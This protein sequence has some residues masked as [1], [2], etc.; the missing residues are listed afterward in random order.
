MRICLR[1]RVLEPMWFPKCVKWEAH[2]VTKGN[3][4]R[5]HAPKSQDH[6]T[7][8]M[9][10]AAHFNQR[11]WDLQERNH[12]TQWYPVQEPVHHHP[13]GNETRN[14]LQ[15]PCKSPWYWSVLTES[16]RCSFLNRNEQWNKGSNLQVFC[17]RSFKQET[18]QSH[19]RCQ[20]LQIFPG[21][22]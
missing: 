22:D 2:A 20:Q 14:C 8:R 9:A 12:S 6:S 15:K 4:T 18:P 5:L 1:S 11:I 16:T 13:P 3:R 21:V 7:C 10:R 17:V 19:C